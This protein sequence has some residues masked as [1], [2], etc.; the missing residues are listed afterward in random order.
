MESILPKEEI[1]ILFEN[2]DYIIRYPL[3]VEEMLLS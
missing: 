1:L 2:K 3:S